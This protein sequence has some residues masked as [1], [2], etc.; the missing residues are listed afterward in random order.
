MKKI[1]FL[2]LILLFILGCTIVPKFK[3]TKELAVGRGIRM[4]F[5][6]N[7]PPSEVKGPFRVGLKFTNNN[8]IEIT[9]TLNLRDVTT[10]EGFDTVNQQV[11]LESAL[12]EYAEPDPRTGELKIK[13]F[14]P[15]TKFEDFGRI[16][17][18][19]VLPG[20]TTQFIAELDFDYS[21]TLNAQFCIGSFGA[22][23]V[24]CPAQE[25]LSGARLG[26]ENQFSPITATINKRVTST[27]PGE[28]LLELEIALNNVGGGE[29]RGNEFVIASID[30]IGDGITLD[31]NSLNAISSNGNQF[32]LML[33]NNKAKINCFADVSF[34]GDLAV[35][36]V[37]ATLNYP[38]RLVAKT[39][40]IKVNPITK[41]L[42]L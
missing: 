33:E 42:S 21:S 9:G 4:E 15:S 24:S 2:V 11:Y 34:A 10:Y 17:Y 40:S 26:L 36:N 28:A 8:P 6:P 19:E 13:S 22:R 38:Y 12:L 5:V 25:T 7:M 31:C 27:T 39:G 1:F 41:G 32:E 30:A 23:T 35:Y 14:A 29:I 37:Y 20:A 16:E 18:K 3:P